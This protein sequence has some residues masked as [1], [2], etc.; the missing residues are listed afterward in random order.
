[1]STQAITN[2]GRALFASKQAAGEPLTID[3]FML[4]NI[5][6]L[7]HTQAVNLNE[8]LPVAGDQV[9]TLP[10]T[11]AGYI[12]PDEVVYSLYLPSTEGDYTYN[13]IGLLADD[14][15][16]IAAAYLSPVDKVAS[17]AGSVGNTLNENIMLAYT[18][19]QAITNLTVDADSWQWQFDQATSTLKGVV[20]LA[21]QVEM[22]AGTDSS[23][24]PPVDVVS[25]FVKKI[26]GLQ[27]VPIGTPLAF[28]G[29]VA[30]N[31]F[32]KMNGAEVLRTIYSDLFSVIGTTYGDGD[33]STTF[34]LPD[35]RGEFIR[36]WDDGRGIDSGRL[37]GS[38]QSDLYKNHQH[39]INMQRSLGAQ[40]SIIPQ[41][42]GGNNS[43]SFN[44]NGPSDLYVAMSSG[45]QYSGG[46]ETRPRN[47]AFMGVIKY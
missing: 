20:E 1:M 14:D 26:V 5:S 9:K 13:W 23:R 11:K 28:A 21:E 2:A 4:A 24:V 36:F 31:G 10:V 40:H 15:T 39:I 35:S 29:S 7:D 30:P 38:F 6:G 25:A 44:A 42:N 12:G 43:Y 3:R 45:T 22:D 46:T 33:G 41:V 8:G 27:G 18:D 16:L 37:I 17:T 47:I 32:L 19:A 34:N